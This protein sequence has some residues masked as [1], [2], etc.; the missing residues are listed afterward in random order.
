MSTT[1]SENVELLLKLRNFTESFIDCYLQM[2]SDWINF[3]MLDT[4]MIKNR[5]IGK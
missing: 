4:K 3:K 2:Q 5:K 1:N